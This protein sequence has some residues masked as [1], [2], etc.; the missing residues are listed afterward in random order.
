MS[1]IQISKIQQR[2]GDLVDLPQLD[3]AEFG[4][5]AD[6]NRLFIGKTAG[7]T[8][9]IEVLTAY[10]DISFN[11]IDGAIGNLN[12][13]AN[14]ANGEV[15]VFDGNNWVNRGG[16]AGGYINLG[17]VS[18]LS[19]AGGGIDY[20]L[21]TDGTGNLNWT[22]KSTVVQYIKTVS[23]ANPA[24]ITTTQDHYL[25]NGAEVTITG[26]P[27]SGASSIANALNGT[28][29]FIGNLTNNTFAL[30]NDITLTSP[31]NTTS[32]NVFP[33]TT[34]TA[35]TNLGDII[36]VANGLP[37]TANM[38]VTF[39]GNTGN[40]NLISNT[41]YY[42]TSAGA[43]SLTVS[44]TQGGSNVALAATSGLS[45]EVYG[46][47]GKI[48]TVVGGSEGSANAGGT[49]TC[50]QFNTNNLLDGSANFT[51]N[52][53]TNNLVVSPGNIIVGNNII[54]NGNLTVGGTATISNLDVTG[55]FTSTG[56]LDL[57]DIANLTIGGG[58][59]GQVLTTYGNG[60]VYWGVGGGGAN[61]GGYYL[62]TQSSASATWLI[63]HNLNTEFVNVNPVDTSG[64]SYYGRYD[65]PSVT[66]NNSN[67]LTLTWSSAVAGNC[68]VIAGGVNG[69]GSP[70]G[71]N[72]QVQFN[73]G[74]S[75]FGGSAGLTFNK[76][77]G[78][79]NAS[80]VQTSNLTTGSSATVGTITGN[81]SLSG[82]S[83][84]TATYADL[85]EY[86]AADKPY[87][88]GTVLDFGGEFEVTVAGIESNKIAGV[89]SAEPAYAMNG[90]IN[91]Q[92][93]I[94]IALQGRVPCKVK[95]KV[96]KGDMM[97]SAGDGYAKA[98]VV[99]PKM[100]TVI[101]KALANF[102][103]EEGVIEV[104]VGRL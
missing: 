39:L 23:T 67:A 85:A 87:P 58:A 22:P 12:I 49:N 62:H 25:T 93:P 19:I 100:G 82:G 21:T 84:L 36:T 10:S 95:G 34:A 1:I 55:T 65:F 41:T 68:S 79:L 81:W 70:G 80:T 5:A 31:V 74:G 45:L 69:N 44:L 42:V 29:K 13:S 4:F 38:A 103:G 32:L 24:V 77:T 54:A 92:H 88:A 56:P 73:D 57:G 3:Q 78:V 30:Y 60:T 96:Q 101:G 9:N 63:T 35:T 72:T 37:F 89:V 15:L 11:Q 53:T 104:V 98:A 66:Y 50:V 6:V 102:D 27:V 47:G 7:N 51:F 94:M 90:S 2:S 83:L 97:I 28:S 14:V 76:S 99:S 61:G 20:V 33:Y 48:T 46:S 8:E 18:N 17:H 26:I 16:N 43:T 91:C 71:A 40:S 86:Y 52:Q 59:N 64:N 75:V